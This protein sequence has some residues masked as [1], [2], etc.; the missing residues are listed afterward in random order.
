MEKL[1]IGERHLYFNDRPTPCKSSPIIPSTKEY[2]RVNYNKFLHNFSISVYADHRLQRR[3]LGMSESESESELFDAAAATELVNTLRRS[4]TTGRT[5]SYEWRVSQL[6]SLL[7]LSQEHE[8]DLC[9]ALHSD[10]SKPVLESI[11][12][13]CSVVLSGS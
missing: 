10:L 12:H 9:D 3:R 8:E 1:R 4:F 5:R 13:E 2:Y 6:E 7:K 11:V